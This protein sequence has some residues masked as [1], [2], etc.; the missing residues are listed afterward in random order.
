MNN[1]SIN[2]QD[3]LSDAFN[4]SKFDQSRLRS[5]YSPRN[6]FYLLSLLRGSVPSSLIRRPDMDLEQ[7]EFLIDGIRYVGDCVL[8]GLIA[9]AFANLFRK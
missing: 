9:I 1:L 7:S 2:V 4:D 8:W 5:I 3:F 6:R